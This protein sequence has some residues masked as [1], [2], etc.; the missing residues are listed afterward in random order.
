MLNTAKIVALLA[1]AL[2]ATTAAA[3]RGA[4]S[5]DV[6]IKTSE[7]TIVV[8][9][10]AA[11]A[12]GTVK[13]FLHYVDAHTYDN[14][15]FYRT[16]SRAREPQSKIEVIQGGLNPQTANPMIAPIPLEPTNKTGLHNTDG[17]ISMARTSDPN[18]ATTEFFICIGD[19]R[20]LDAGGP[21]GPGYAAFG[22][23]IR[24]AD[25]VRKIERSNASGESLT[26]PIRII[27]ITRAR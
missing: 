16:V 22:K 18:S 3:P 23:V 26:P 6:A 2:F 1:A 13:N 5:T 17:V 8:R 14:T 7:G 10:D 21:L 27:S 19:N 20:F 11:H 24:G 4:P 25:V 15:T 12:P 9:P